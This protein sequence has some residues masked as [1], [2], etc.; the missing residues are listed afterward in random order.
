MSYYMIRNVLCKYVNTCNLH[1]N[2][3]Y[4]NIYAS[5]TF[6]TLDARHPALFVISALLKSRPPSQSM[7]TFRTWESRALSCRICLALN[8]EV[9]IISPGAASGK[10][11]G[12]GGRQFPPSLGFSLTVMMI[13]YPYPIMV[14]ILLQM[15]SVGGK[16]VSESPPPP[17]LP[18]AL[19]RSGSVLSETIYH[20]APLSKHPGA[21][22]AFR[23][24]VHYLEVNTPGD[25]GAD[26]ADMGS[27]ISNF[28]KFMDRKFA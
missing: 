5:R 14:I 7:F 8:S 1:Q 21:A 16:N 12:G 18:S 17:P 26:G 20:F 2:V 23:S 10:G 11:G 15:F 28:G 22:P 6:C 27:V 3:W 25:D 13:I 24:C 19:S 4:V 9:C